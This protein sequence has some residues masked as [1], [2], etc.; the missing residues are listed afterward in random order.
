MSPV[1]P[2]LLKLAMHSY[3]QS[4]M[5]CCFV[6][7]WCNLEFRQFF[8]RI[9]HVYYRDDYCLLFH[10]FH[11]DDYCHVVVQLGGASLVMA[12]VT[13]ESPSKT[14]T[15]TTT[16]PTMLTAAAVTSR[17]S[18]AAVTSG[19]S[20]VA[21]NSSKFSCR[22]CQKTYSSQPSLRI[23]EKWHTGDL[24]HKCNFCVKRFRNPSEVKRH[25]MTH[26]G[27]KEEQGYKYRPCFS[28]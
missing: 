21:E 2:T 24:K 17:V 10:Y 11:I 7:N 22:Y 18:P 14:A 1:S 5:S 3:A 13:T 20:P 27:R 15:M 23:H 12:T 6:I 16:E 19:V 26:T 8:C 9:Y 28:K 4:L 25:E